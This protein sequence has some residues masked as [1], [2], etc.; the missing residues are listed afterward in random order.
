M[1]R[2]I[3]VFFLILASLGTA[4]AQDPGW[5]PQIVKPQGTLV[6]YQPQEQSTHNYQQRQHSYGGGGGGRGRR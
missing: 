2:T 6:Y 1:K 5:P 4:S 3:A